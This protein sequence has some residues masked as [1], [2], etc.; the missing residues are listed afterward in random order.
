MKLSNLLIVNYKSCKQVAIDLFGNAPTVLIGKND[1]GK[2]T[3]L[4]A[5]GLLLSDKPRVP[6]LSDFSNTRCSQ[7]DYNAQF[8]ALGVPILEYREQDCV[9]VGQFYIDETLFE[10]DKINEYSDQLLLSFHNPLQAANPEDKKSIFLARR[11]S[12]SGPHETYI[13]CK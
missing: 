7:E 1:C 8:S 11:F 2:S 3:V 12:P 4:N 6:L 13:I 5:I 9:V 10:E